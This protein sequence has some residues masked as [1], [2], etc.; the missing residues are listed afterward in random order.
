MPLA[1]RRARSGTPEV[2]YLRWGLRR[3]RCH[4][5]VLSA[6]DVSHL[7]AAPALMAQA[8]HA[9]GIEVKG[10][11]FVERRAGDPADDAE[12]WKV[13]ADY[14]NSGCFGVALN[15]FVQA[16]PRAL[17][18]V[19]EPFASWHADL[20]GFAAPADQKFRVGFFDF[21]EGQAFKLAVIQ[22]ADSMFDHHG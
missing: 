5:A 1:L 7:P 4:G 21:V 19:G 8:R 20:R 10:T 14:Q 13:V 9:A 16:V 17:G 2:L 3:C 11:I 22:L 15:D 18:H 12:N 6:V